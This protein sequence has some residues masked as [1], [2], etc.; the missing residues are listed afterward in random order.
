M[1]EEQKRLVARARWARKQEYYDS[2]GVW[3]EANGVP[4]KRY[5]E[6]LDKWDPDNL[7]VEEDPQGRVIIDRIDRRGASLGTLAG[8]ELVAKFDI[9]DRRRFSEF[10]E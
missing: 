7:T 10:G 1:N 9:H 6:G 3:I 8:R 5:F 2:S 4:S